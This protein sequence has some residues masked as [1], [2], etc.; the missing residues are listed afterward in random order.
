MSQR[1]A[2]RFTPDYVHRL[3]G[4][5]LLSFTSGPEASVSASAVGGFDVAVAGDGSYVVA[6]EHSVGRLRAVT[7]F[8]YAASGEPAG[9]PIRLYT[10]RLPPTANWGKVAASANADGDVVVAYR[11]NDGAGAGVYFNVI[12]STGV[13]GRTV[14]VNEDV[15]DQRVDVSMDDAG[16]VFVAWTFERSQ[17]TDLDARAF[18]AA[19]AP[20]GPRFTLID[21]P[22]LG[23]ADVGDI[24]AV[25]DGS[26]VIFASPLHYSGEGPIA[27]NLVYGHASSLGVVSS[28]TEVE[29]AQDFVEVAVSAYPDG[30]FVLGYTRTDRSGQGNRRAYAQRFNAAAVADGEELSL[31]ASLPSSEPGRWIAVDAAPGGGFVASFVHTMGD[32]AHAY[33]ARFDA[34][35]HL[36]PSGYVPIASERAGSTAD[37]RRFRTTIGAD[38]RGAAVVAYAM[39][40]SDTVRSRRLS[41]DGGAELRGSELY[42]NGTEGD[43]HVIV[44]RVRERLYVNLNG[45]VQRFDAADVQFLSINGF[46][47]DDDIVNASAIPSTIHGGDGA[48]TLWGGTGPDRLRGFGGNDRLFGGDGDDVLLGDNG[49]D[50]LHGGFGT[51]TLSGGAGADTAISGEIIDGRRPGLSFADGIITFVGTDAAA[52]VVSLVRVDLS[53]VVTANGVEEA[54]PLDELTRIE[55]YGRGGH[56]VLELAAGFRVPALIEGGA[57]NDVLAGGDAGDTLFGNDG[58]DDINGRRG[59]DHM[60]G[61]DGNDSMNGGVASD[62]VSGGAGDDIVSGGGEDD[63]VAGGP[64]EDQLGGGGGSTDTLDYSARTTAL[65]LVPDNEFHASGREEVEN[66]RVFDIDRVIGGSGDDYIAVGSTWVFGG[67]G[68]DTIVGG[69]FAERLYGEGGDDDL[70]GGPG[71]GVNYLEGGAGNDTLRSAEGAL[72]VHRDTLFGLAGN[73]RFFTDNG[74]PDVV[75]GGPGDDSADVDGEDDVL[76]VETIT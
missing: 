43:D 51:D 45:A 23:G 67:D 40:S 30:S 52:D 32:V 65:R 63:T 37:A 6:A 8:P 9:E 31:R 22:Q 55:L 61:G 21:G 13:V 11:V 4:R 74:V 42:V 41:I 5:R 73:D 34:A 20:R 18:D 35:G 47:G 27:T 68:D 69:V 14:R 12:S 53:I 62:T 24:A 1:L 54:F 19:G 17:G 36:D 70:D 66:D 72:D 76:A 33:A 57:G 15:D 49:D 64:G 3:E 60:E 28:R 48:D 59:E 58:D 10:Y 7:A 29:H 26:G 46:G 38:A 75:R 56:D 39:G 25:P 50:A 2:H 71:S 16:G 44:E